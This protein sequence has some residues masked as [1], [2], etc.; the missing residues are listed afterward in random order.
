MN[1]RSIAGIVAA[2]LFTGAIFSSPCMAG[3]TLNL[4]ESNRVALSDKVFELQHTE[5]MRVN[6]GRLK[7]NPVMYP[8]HTIYQLVLQDQDLLVRRQADGFE[9]ALSRLDKVLGEFPAELSTARGQKAAAYFRTELVR[10]YDLRAPLEKSGTLLEVSQAFESSMFGMEALPIR[11]GLALDAIRWS[12]KIQDEVAPR[13]IFDKQL[14]ALIGKWDPA[15]DVFQFGDGI[16]ALSK[17]YSKLFM[18][19]AERGQTIQ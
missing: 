6:R 5:L 12:S 2:A 10:I 3:E 11:A 7:S 18:S 9:G 1:P 17:E 19:V 8:M 15:F 16:S 14:D 13:E 4:T